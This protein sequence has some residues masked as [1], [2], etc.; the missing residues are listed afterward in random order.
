MPG[1]VLLTRKEATVPSFLSC[2]S[3]SIRELE[4]KHVVVDIIKERQHMGGGAERR[5][6]V[7]RTWAYWC[8]VFLGLLVGR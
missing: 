3:N 7:G 6:Q 2:L 8:A 4:L 5:Q 1:S